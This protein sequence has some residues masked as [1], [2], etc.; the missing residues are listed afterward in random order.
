MTGFIKDYRKELDSNVWLMPPLYHR[1]WQWIK[2]N[3]NHAPGEVPFLDGTIV[4]VEPGERVTSLRQI[5]NGVGYYERGIWREPNAKTI[6]QILKWLET[7]QM[8]AVK[9]NSGYTHL[10]VLNWGIYQSNGD[11]K[12]N[13][14]ETVRKQSL[15]PNKNDKND[16]KDKEDL[17]G[18]FVRLEKVE[19]ERLVDRL[20][21][22]STLDYIDRLNNYIGSSGKKYKSHYHTILQWVRKDEAKQEPRRKLDIYIPEGD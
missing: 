14:E 19:Y 12:S 21:E 11:S 7:E 22:P 2:Y 20:G 8:I 1:V 9:S 13:S 18:E 16:K 5:A 4:L 10:K 15:D 17:Y 6:R 3:V